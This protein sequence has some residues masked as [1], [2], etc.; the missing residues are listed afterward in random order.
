MTHLTSLGPRSHL[1]RL[2]QR[3]SGCYSRFSWA[4]KHILSWNVLDK[5][6]L[7]RSP[8]VNPFVPN[9]AFLHISARVRMLPFGNNILYAPVAPNSEVAMVKQVD[10]TLEDAIG[11]QYSS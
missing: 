4:R 10:I 11:Y 1:F 9:V 2:L 7:V 8:I 5:I 6:W 3:G